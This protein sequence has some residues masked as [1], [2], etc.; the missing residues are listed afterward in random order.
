MPDA[1]HSA[2]ESGTS[3]LL[4]EVRV[5]LCSTCAKLTCATGCGQIRRLQV[6]RGRTSP[7]G[8]GV[9]F[10]KRASSISPGQV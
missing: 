7:G 6:D 5:Q 8:V 3:K 4:V 2:R 10:V 1:G 9:G